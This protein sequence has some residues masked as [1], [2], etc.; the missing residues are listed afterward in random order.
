MDCLKDQTTHIS[1]NAEYCLTGSSINHLPSTIND[2]I[3]GSC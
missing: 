2:Y 3:A 1:V